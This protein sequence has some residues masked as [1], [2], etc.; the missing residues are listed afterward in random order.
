[1]L[2]SGVR[3]VAGQT[4]VAVR[5]ERSYDD[6]EFGP[7]CFAG[8]KRME[9]P[10]AGEGVDQEEPSARLIERSWVTK[11]RRTRVAVIYLNAQPTICGLHSEPWRVCPG[12]LKRIADQFGY[13]HRRRFLQVSKL[14][15]G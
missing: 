15:C 14:P 11:P 12:V 3:F 2:A 6:V 1:M 5:V 9:S 10:S 7:D 13:D 4:P 8:A